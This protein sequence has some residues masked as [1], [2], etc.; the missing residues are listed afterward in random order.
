MDDVIPLASATLL[1]A[2]APNVADWLEAWA[3]AVAAIGTVG[4][5]IWQARSIR[6]E[7]QTRKAEIARLEGDQQDLRAAQART[8]IVHKPIANAVRLTSNFNKKAEGDRAVNLSVTIGNYGSEVILHVTPIL[9]GD[10]KNESYYAQ[11]IETLMAGCTHEFSWILTGDRYLVADMAA[12]RLIAHEFDVEV[13]FTDIHGLR[14][15]VRPGAGH[16]PVPIK[17]MYEPVGQRKYEPVKPRGPWPPA[18]RDAT[19]PRGS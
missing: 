7:R 10:D 13:L 14:W 18:R 5:F 9:R 16:P 12:Q 19:A 1:A 6:Q 2:D 8:I 11:P 15:A 3:T 4:A 17:A